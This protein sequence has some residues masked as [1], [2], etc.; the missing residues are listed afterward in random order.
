M[1]ETDSKKSDFTVIFTMDRLARGKFLRFMRPDNTRN[2]KHRPHVFVPPHG[3]SQMIRT[4]LCNRNLQEFH[5]AEQLRLIVH[6]LRWTNYE[7][8]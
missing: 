2:R 4:S 3:S 6:A 8:R 7:G 1:A 5:A